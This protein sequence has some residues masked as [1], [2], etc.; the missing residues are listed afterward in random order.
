MASNLQERLDNLRQ[1]I[2]NAAQSGEPNDITQLER[3]ARTL[4][5]DAKNT[6]FE[7]AAQA[8]F[9]E[10]ARLSSPTSPTAAT[11]RGLV[12]RARIRIE[13]AGDDDDVDEAIDI[14]AE[15]L[16][17]NPQDADVIALLQEAA[18]RSQQATQRVNDLY[19]R[20]GV[21]RPAA[22]TTTTALAP[23]IP[24]AVETSRSYPTSS[25]Y[26]APE[27]EIY[28][29]TSSTARRMPGRS[30]GAYN[31]MDVDEFVSD[32]TQSYYAGDYQQTVDLANRILTHQPGNPAAL[33]YR[34][35]AEECR[36][37]A[38]RATDAATRFEWITMAQSWDILAHHAEKDEK[39]G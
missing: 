32:L 21:Q 25:G 38:S 1:Q 6:A 33:E 26:P 15:A 5:A 30:G 35:K 11:V 39:S 19:A 2:Q 36:A 34:Q 23:A 13:I 4:L 31:S 16:G 29:D 37:R 17:L 28:E 14:L 27:A 20:Y 3:T 8:L 22:P 7:A 18:G 24:T 9:G 10:L 12:R